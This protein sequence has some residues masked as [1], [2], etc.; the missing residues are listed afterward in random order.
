MSPALANGLAAT[1]EKTGTPP[2]LPLAMF[3]PSGAPG[4]GPLQP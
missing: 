1:L 4:I 2:I 3:A